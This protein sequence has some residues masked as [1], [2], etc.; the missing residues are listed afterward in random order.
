MEDLSSLDKAK[1]EEYFKKL[2]RALQAISV[3]DRSDILME[4]NSHIMDSFGKGNQ[5]LDDIL[6]ALGDPTQVA[7]RYL[8]AKGAQIAPPPRPHVFRWVVMGMV[9]IFCF[10]VIGTLVLVSMFLPILEID[11]EKGRLSILGGMLEINESEGL[12]SLGKGLIKIAGEEIEIDIESVKL[13]GS[14]SSTDFETLKIEGNN[15]KFDFEQGE[16]SDIEYNCKIIKTNDS[17]DLAKI[18]KEPGGKVLAFDFTQQIRG[19]SCEFKIPRGMTLNTEL[20]NGKVELDELHQDISVAIDNGKISFERAH[21]AQY[22][23]DARITN[24]KINGIREIPVL[25]T[26]PGVYKVQ[27][28]VTNGK[29]DVD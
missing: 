16:T 23:I 18:V 6:F 21:D 1:L 25:K 12:L 17:F 27:L 10:L 8:L 2:E 15:G 5:S 9:S 14:L 7:N 19:A 29:I 26:G 4:L 22:S 28:D 20:I 3:V 13:S 24:G 11:S